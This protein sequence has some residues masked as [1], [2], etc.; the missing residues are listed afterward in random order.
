MVDNELDVMKLIDEKLSEIKD[1]NSRDRILK[2]AWSKFSSKPQINPIGDNKPEETTGKK[3]NK[4]TIKKSSKKLARKKP[5]YTMVKTLNLRPT[6]KKSFID[7]TKELLP[8][9]N[10]EKCVVCAYYLCK[11][12]VEKVD[13]NSIYTCFKTMGWRLPSDINGVLY[14]ISSQKAWLDTSNILDIKL[15]VHGDNLIEHDLPRKKNK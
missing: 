9:N 5:T 7:F 8:S 15:T 4:K 6:D 12:L 1:S 3:K 10:P 11:I 14:W 2:W 13:S